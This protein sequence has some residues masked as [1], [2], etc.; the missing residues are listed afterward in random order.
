MNMGQWDW[1]QGYYFVL[2][3]LGIGIEIE[4]DGEM[5]EGRH[6]FSIHF[7]ATVCSFPIIG[8]VFNLW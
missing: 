2:I 3:V 8:R 4:R 1:I 5:K 6:S 7:I